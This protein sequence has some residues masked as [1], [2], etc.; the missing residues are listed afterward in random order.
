MTGRER[1][2][3]TLTGRMP[4]RVPMCETTFWPATL[5]RWHK[6]G[7]PPGCDPVDYFGLDKIVPGV[8]FDGTFGL[9]VKTLAETEKFIVEKDGFGATWKYW[10]NG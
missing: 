3:A 2:I 6:E 8:S 1:L 5:E 10:K 9:E 4:D 7:L